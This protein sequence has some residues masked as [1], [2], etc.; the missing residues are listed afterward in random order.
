[1]IK[2]TKLQKVL[3]MI[4]LVFFLS[5]VTFGMITVSASVLFLPSVCAAFAI[6]RDLIEGKYNVYD[7]L[8]KGFFRELLHYKASL[9]FFPAQL[10]LVLQILS[11]KAAGTFGGF[12]FQILL[13]VIAAFLLTFLLYACAFLVLVEE[14]MRVEEIVVRMFRRI[15]CLV[16]LFTLMILLLL[17]AD[18]RL[19]VIVL[20]AGALVLLAAEACIYH[21]LFG[22]PNGQQDSQPDREKKGNT[23]EAGQGR[24]GMV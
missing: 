13:L 1:M 3:A 6:G 12:Y 23:A 5:F 7:G 16:S 21:S 8:V 15:G 4:H 2:E 24:R 19:F 22:Q 18:A 11:M 14:R 9:R 17:F 20:A 10:I